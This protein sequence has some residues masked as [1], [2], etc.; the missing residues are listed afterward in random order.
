MRAAQARA[1]LTPLEL[2]LV[3]NLTLSGMPRSVALEIVRSTSGR[4]R[5]LRRR[6]QQWLNR[7][8]RRGARAGR[9]GARAAGERLAEQ[10]QQDRPGDALMDRLRRG[11]PSIGS[12]GGYFRAGGGRLG[13]SGLHDTVPVPGGM[14]APGELVVNRHTEGKVNA[15]L[16]RHG[17]TLEGMTDGETKKHSEPTGVRGGILAGLTHGGRTFAA[18]GRQNAAAGRVLAEA[19]RMS[20]MNSSYLYGG[21]HVTPAPGEPPWDCS[22][23]VSRLLQAG[24]LGTPT[25]TS[26]QMMGIG[27]PGKGW[28]TIY[29][30]PGHVYSTIGGRAWGTSYSR[31]NGG[32]GWFAGGPRSGFAVRHIPQFGRGATSGGGQPGGA[33]GGAPAR[34]RRTMTGGILGSSTSQ[35]FGLAGIQFAGATPAAPGAPGGPAGPAAPAAPG[36]GTNRQIGR[37]MMLA[38]GW[39]AGQWP[40]LNQLWTGES[41]WRTT[42]DNPSSDAYGIPSR[43]PARRMA[44]KG[45]DWKTNPRTQ[46]RVG[47]RLHQGPLRLPVGGAVRV[48]RTKPHW[49]GGGGRMRWGG[50]H[51]LGLDRTFDTPTMIGVGE[52]GAERVKVTPKGKGGGDA[53]VTIN[54]HFNIHGGEPGRVKKEV[55]AAME[56]FARRLEHLGYSGGDD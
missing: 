40:A 44:S 52:G 4:P 41:G 18:G 15:M 25:M 13:G 46:I 51:Q 21:G 39:G 48:A 24:G 22:S 1:R 17:R 12:I 35:L 34:P 14:A 37:R 31:P 55:E 47:P 45:A 23:S 19:N 8:R 33:P 36:G 56:S 3:A 20:A 43:C 6:I 49:Y 7:Q 16:A 38:H 42:A 26:G 10:A 28:F 53:P 9:A 27:A 2:D 29:A 50:W 30:S 5:A 11:V 32:P 54:A